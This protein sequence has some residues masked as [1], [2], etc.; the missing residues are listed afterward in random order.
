M[1]CNFT[2]QSK[3]EL[4][5]ASKV[6]AASIRKIL[7]ADLENVAL[8]GESATELAEVVPTIIHAAKLAAAAT[9]VPNLDQELI[10]YDVGEIPELTPIARLVD[11]LKH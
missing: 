11:S 7:G 2:Q 3:D 4:T 8:L 10:R 6:I 5:D 9:S 1:L